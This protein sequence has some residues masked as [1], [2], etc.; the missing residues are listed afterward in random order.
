M[1]GNAQ[2]AHAPLS[3]GPAPPDA[4]GIGCAFAAIYRHGR[5]VPMLRTRMQD[6][7]TPSPR[8][9][10]YLL[11]RRVPPI[12]GSFECRG[13]PGAATAEKSRLI[14]WSAWSHAHWNGRSRC[15]P[16]RVDLARPPTGPRGRFDGHTSQLPGRVHGDGAWRLP[17][18]LRPSLPISVEWLSRRLAQQSHAC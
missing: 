12:P 1:P 7:Q 16:P 15:S 2:A 6:L 13:Y 8:F 4:S 10:P 18:T 14:W 17:C 5:R 3:A 9:E 11:Q